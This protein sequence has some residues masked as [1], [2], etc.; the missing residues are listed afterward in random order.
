MNC[1]RLIRR[2]V[3]N[4]TT[5]AA[6]VIINAVFI[7]KAIVSFLITKFCIGNIAPVRRILENLIFGTACLRLERSTIAHIKANVIVSAAKGRN[8]YVHKIHNAVTRTVVLQITVASS[9]VVKITRRITYARFVAATVIIAAEIVRTA[10]IIVVAANVI[11]SR[12]IIVVAVI[13][14]VATVIIIVAI[15]IVTI[16]VVISVVII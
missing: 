15:V 16:I 10:I 4:I 1:Y 8:I 9:D 2:Y 14:M 13:M 12:I 5:R 6:A 7:G 11:G 3:Q